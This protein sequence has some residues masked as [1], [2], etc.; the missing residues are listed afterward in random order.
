MVSTDLIINGIPDKEKRTCSDLFSSLCNVVGVEVPPVRDIFRLPP[1]KDNVSSPIIVKLSCAQSRNQL[2]KAVAGFCKEKQRSITLKDIGLNDQ[3]NVY[4][5]ESLTKVNRKIMFYAAQLKRQNLLSA[6][7]S[8][9]GQIFV[10]MQKGADAVRVFNKDEI[11][12]L[13][14]AHA[15]SGAQA[16]ANQHSAESTQQ[17]S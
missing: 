17:C 2:F 16:K 8:I 1:N 12:K 10:R 7:F 4:L 5:H 6:A 9:R 15:L 14:S 3:T 13:V 11:D